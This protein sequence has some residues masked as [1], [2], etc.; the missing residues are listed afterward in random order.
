MTFAA[1]NCNYFFKSMH[2][3]VPDLT[4]FERHNFTSITNNINNF[5]LYLKYF[6]YFNMLLALPN[7]STI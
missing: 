1:Y 7:W 6:L 3:T 4:R 5:W 2:T